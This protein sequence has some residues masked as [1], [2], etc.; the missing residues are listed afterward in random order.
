MTVGMNKGSCSLTES[1]DHLIIHKYNFW[2]LYLHESQYYLGRVYLLANNAKRRDFLD[3]SDAETEEFFHI[4]RVVKS[5]LKLLFQPDKFNYAA[6]SN[7]FPDLHIHIIPRYQ[8]PRRFLGK[9]FI[10]HNWGKNFA[11]YDKNF[12]VEINLKN[13]LI[14]CI[15]ETLCVHS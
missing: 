2:T 10:D 5:S 6:L 4:S 15:K 14:D 9:E 3:I 13:H 11:P 7:V 8:T 1:Y 12:I